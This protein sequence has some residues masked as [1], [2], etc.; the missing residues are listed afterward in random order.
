MKKAKKLSSQHAVTGDPGQEVTL[1]LSGRLAL[2][3]LSLLTAE[4]QARLRE[5]RPA[6]LTIDWPEWTTWTAPGPWP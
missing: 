2:D 3:N 1:A 4:M 5:L 6:G